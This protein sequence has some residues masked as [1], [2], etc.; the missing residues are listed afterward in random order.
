MVFCAREM[1]C[2]P[3]AVNKRIFHGFARGQNCF[4][5]TF[6]LRRGSMNCGRLSL[7]WNGAREMRENWHE[8]FAGALGVR[9]SASHLWLAL[10]KRK[11]MRREAV[12][13]WAMETVG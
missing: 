10:R 9:Q 11:C 2:K 8:R 4:I 13:A 6:W 7:L 5:S 12:G 3:R 1:I